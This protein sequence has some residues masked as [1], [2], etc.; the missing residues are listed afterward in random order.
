MF[1]LFF[2]AVFDQFV[3]RILARFLT[4]VV[5]RFLTRFLARVLTMVWGKGKN[6][7]Y[8]VQYYP[9]QG[10]HQQPKTNTLIK[11]CFLRLVWCFFAFKVF[12]LDRVVLYTV[13]MI[14][15]IPQTMVKTLAKN[16][17][18]NLAKIRPSI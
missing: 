13:L 4:R 5:D 11:P 14:F 8:S 9:D 1:S 16:L 10:K 7:K 17:V 3:G 6:H 2:P 12:S 15:P 18:K